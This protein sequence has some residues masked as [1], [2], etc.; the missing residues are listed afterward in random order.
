MELHAKGLAK[1][2]EIRQLLYLSAVYKYKNIT[3]ASKSLYVSQPTVSAAVK[4]LESEFG[5]SLIDRTPRGL[6][7]TQEGEAMMKRISML[8]SDYNDM[9]SE[10]N[11][12]NHKT[13]FTLR[14]GIASILSEDLFPL[15][16]KDFL[17]MHRDFVIRLD[18]DSAHGQIR[19]ILNEELDLAI[20]GLPDD[21]DTNEFKTI[22]IS[23]REIKLILHKDHP[24]AQ[25][26]TVPV[27]SLDGEDVSIYSPSGVMGQILDEA[28]SKANVHPNIISE[29]SQIHGVLEIVSTCSSIGFLNFAPETESI[30]KAGGVVLR[31]F[32]EPLTFMIGFIMKRRKYL[33]TVCQEFIKFVTEKLGGARPSTL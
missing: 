3:K 33:P 12:L 13:S 30:A 26:E 6:T 11:E 19:K 10:A 21:L 2:I 32:S 22:P 1:I 17:P 28:F 27:E 8:L 14:L 7:F 25:L 9:L 18:E 4:A 23:Q 31:S 15:I 16:Y 24:L 5:F 20:N 29:H